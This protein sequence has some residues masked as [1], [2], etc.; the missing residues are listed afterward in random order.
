MYNQHSN[1]AWTELF[2]RENNLIY[3]D[4][5]IGNEIGCFQKLFTGNFNEITKTLPIHVNKMSPLELE[6][7]ET[8]IDFKYTAE[9]KKVLAGSD[10]FENKPDELQKYL[11][12]N[13]EDKALFV[14]RKRGRQMSLS[15]AFAASSV[16]CVTEKPVAS[17]SKKPR[18]DH[19]PVTPTPVKNTSENIFVTPPAH[20]SSV[21]VKPEHAHAKAFKTPSMREL[22]SAPRFPILSKSLAPSVSSSNGTFGRLKGED[23]K[24]SASTLRYSYSQKAFIDTSSDEDDEL[25]IVD[26]KKICLNSSSD[27]SSDDDEVQIVEEPMRKVNYKSEK[28]HQAPERIAANEQAKMEKDE[29]EKKTKEEKLKNI[30]AKREEAKAAKEKM[31]AERKKAQE[32]AKKAKEEQ[33]ER[34]KQ[35]KQEKQ[36]KAAERRKERASKVKAAGKE[37]ATKTAKGTGKNENKKAKKEAADGNCEMKEEVKVVSKSCFFLFHKY[38]SHILLLY[39]GEEGR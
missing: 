12:Q 29:Q 35:E 18:H 2:M 15:E 4:T 30:E 26:L 6:K 27:E 9:G 37:A 14:S 16:S 39:T 20:T 19:N 8:L 28:V 31:D 36:R 17:P 38:I 13:P 32:D 25:Q 22:S 23:K 24:I 11:L 10:Y 5:A 7:I 33:E 34:E 3:K 21:Q 1:R